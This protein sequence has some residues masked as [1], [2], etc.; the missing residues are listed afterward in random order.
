VKHTV[1]RGIRVPSLK[2]KILPNAVPIV[3]LQS[4]PRRKH[5]TFRY[6]AQPVNAV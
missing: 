6:K 2:C 3:K 5:I 1:E 4:V